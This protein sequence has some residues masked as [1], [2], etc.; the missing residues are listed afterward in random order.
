[1]DKADFFQA[2]GL[3]VQNDKYILRALTEDD[4][5]NYLKLYR[6]NSIIAKVS[7]EMSDVDYDE[8]VEF[9]WEKIPEDDSIIVSVFLKDGNLYVGSI[10]IQHPFS[11]I[12]EIGI[13]VLRR[14]QRQGIAYE[15]IPMFAKRIL[16]LKNIEYFLV[17]I[18]SD[19]IASTEL[20]VK[21]GALRIGHESSELGAVLAQMKEKLKDEYEELLTRN[22]DVEDIANENC[23]VQYK[24]LP[25]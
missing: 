17:R 10:T 3:F 4:K 24:Y 23:I 6:E 8:F 7:S 19:N 14:Y 16:E 1:M 2:D 5:E 25:E 18:Y 9:V 22:P 13:D 12:P 20:F 21:L 15:T 11:D